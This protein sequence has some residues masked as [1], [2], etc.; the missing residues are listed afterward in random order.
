MSVAVKDRRSLPSFFRILISRAPKS[1]SPYPLLPIRYA[2]DAPS[3]GAT[4]QHASVADPVR[5]IHVHQSFID[6]DV[7]CGKLFDWFRAASRKRQ[8][9]VWMSWSG[10]DPFQT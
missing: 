7:F 2:R 8:F 6:T 9:R 1:S 10:A 5:S 3:G 4:D